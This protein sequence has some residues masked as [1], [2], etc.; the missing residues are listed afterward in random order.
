MTTGSHACLN[1]DNR[2]HIYSFERRQMICK[3]IE[4]AIEW[5]LRKGRF[6]SVYLRLLRTTSS[7]AETDN[8]L[9]VVILQK[10]NCSVSFATFLL[11]LQA[12]D[13]DCCVW[14]DI[15][16]V[17]L[18]ASTA[19]S[20]CLSLSLYLS[21]GL[22]FLSISYYLFLSL[23]LCISLTTSLCRS[24]SLSVSVSVSTDRKSVV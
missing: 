16:F 24:M 10:C 5:N 14:M 11:S 21:V 1:Y 15:Y 7:A 19:F 17:E 9:S 23:C 3:H 13:I 12:E 4:G 20:R 22:C 6:L 18:V 8:H 2:Y